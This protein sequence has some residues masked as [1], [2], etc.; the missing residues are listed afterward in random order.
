MQSLHRQVLHLN[1]MA[2]TNDYSQFISDYQ[3]TKLD[4]KHRGNHPFGIPTPTLCNLEITQE[5][6]DLLI[7]AQNKA[8]KMA[9]EAQS[10]SLI[11]ENHPNVKRAYEEYRILLKLI[12]EE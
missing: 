4:I 7:E 9:E 10:E 6:L 5:G 8:T 3:I 2:T 1:N 12:G 11:R